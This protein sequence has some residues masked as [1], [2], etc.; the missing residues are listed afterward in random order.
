MGSSSG[1]GMSMS[2]HRD[3][4]EELVALSKSD[5]P[6]VRF[7]AMRRL[8]YLGPLA[9]DALPSMLERWNDPCWAVRYQVLRAMIHLRPYEY[10]VAPVLSR[11]RRDSDKVVRSFA[12]T[13]AET[14]HVS[15]E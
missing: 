12:N 11:L 9:V 10:D 6:D 13:V 14:I 4:I 8:C 7:D 2:G 1:R 15:V 5:D 3:R